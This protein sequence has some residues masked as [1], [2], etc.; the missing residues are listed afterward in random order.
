MIRD[1]WARFATPV[2]LALC[3]LAGAIVEAWR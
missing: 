2:V 1:L 3:L